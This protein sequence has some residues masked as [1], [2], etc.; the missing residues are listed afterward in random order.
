MQTEINFAFVYFAALTRERSKILFGSGGKCSEIIVSGGSRG[1]HWLLALTRLESGDATRMFLWLWMNYL[2]NTYHHH[3]VLAVQW[4][5]ISYFGSVRS[6]RSQ[7]VHLSLNN[8][9][10]SS[11]FQAVLSAFSQLSFS[12]HSVIQLSFSSLSALF[13]FSFIFH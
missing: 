6:S 7:N 3:K 12:P 2:W 10:F 13:Q 5:H 4:R 9:L 8:H 1:S 11:A